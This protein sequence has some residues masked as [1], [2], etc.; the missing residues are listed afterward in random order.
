MLRNDDRINSLYIL[1][2]ICCFMKKAVIIK[3]Y[4]IIFLN[5]KYICIWGCY[6][7]YALLVLLLSLFDSPLFGVSEEVDLPELFEGLD[8]L[9]K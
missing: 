6:F 2:I 7:Y 1:P 8:L 4:V 9:L 3:Y 5:K